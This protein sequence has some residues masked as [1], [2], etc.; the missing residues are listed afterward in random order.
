MS[1]SGG[2]WLGFPGTVIA[3]SSDQEEAAFR[4]KQ[5]VHEGIRE[6]EETSKAGCS[7]GPY[8]QSLK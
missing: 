2:S 5:V 7:H 6:Q 1:T 3:V 4:E 8:G